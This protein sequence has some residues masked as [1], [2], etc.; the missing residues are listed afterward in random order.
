MIRY[1][2]DQDDARAFSDVLTAQQEKD[3]A[4][5]I[6][7]GGEAAERARARFLEAN[8]RLVYKVA[9]RYQGHGLDLE[10]LMQEGNIGLMRAVDKFDPARGFKFST[11]AWWWI[12][13]AITRAIQDASRTIR[14][15][16]H[17][18]EALRRVHKHEMRLAASLDRLP[19]SEELAEAT[20][21]PVARIEQLRAI[22]WTVSLDEP[23][24]EEDDLSLEGIIADPAAASVEERVTERM[25]ASDVE[26]ILRSALTPRELLVI[27]HRFG[28]G[29]QPEQR[30]AQVGRDLGIS[31]ERVRQIEARAL[32]KLRHS[33]HLL[34]LVL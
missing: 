16:V 25:L 19:S 11:M 5:I 7:A 28:L 4:Q 14:L 12:K 6:A 29:E 31:R 3:L 20:G 9:M 2:N 18:H 33:S 24:G 32:A 10:D 30:L 34:A 15:P 17:L 13:Q 23:L 8:Q 1:H 26:Q 22:P 27:Q 21:S